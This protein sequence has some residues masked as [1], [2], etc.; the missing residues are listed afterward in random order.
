MKLS[1]KNG[2]YKLNYFDVGE[3]S[4][5]YKES[6]DT[7]YLTS[8]NQP[9]TILPCESECDFRAGFELPLQVYNSNGCL[10]EEMN[11]KL[12][13]NTGL[14]PLT[15]IHFLPDQ[16]IVIQVINLYRIIW[17]KN[18][19]KKCYLKLDIKIDRSVYFNSFPLCKKNS[20]LTPCSYNKN[21][22]FKLI[23]GFDFTP[24][25]KGR[26]GQKYYLHLSG[27]GTIH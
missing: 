25:K 18:S 12:D 22:V 10:L 19:I 16:I 21:K 3:D 23:N 9:V 5:T 13:T 15:D 6:N 7:I 4:G 8:A 24:L 17:P 27:H 11:V 26:K 2:V 1:L 14:I 20:F